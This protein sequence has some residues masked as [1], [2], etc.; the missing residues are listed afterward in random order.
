M[1]INSCLLTLSGVALCYIKPFAA[2]K[3]HTSLINIYHYVPASDYIN[4]LLSN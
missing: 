1:T 4:P 2:A 3:T